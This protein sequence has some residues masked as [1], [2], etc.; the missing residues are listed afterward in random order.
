MLNKLRLFRRDWV[1]VRRLWWGQTRRRDTYDII[2]VN[3]QRHPAAPTLEKVFWYQH[4]FQTERGRDCLS[5]HRRD[6]CRRV[7]E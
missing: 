6:L 3:G 7:Q 4:L 5:H 1:I 2:D